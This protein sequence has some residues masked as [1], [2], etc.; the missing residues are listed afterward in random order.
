[1]KEWLFHEWMHIEFWR[2]LGAGAMILLLWPMNRFILFLFG[3]K[4]R[5]LAQ[6]TKSE[7]DDRLVEVLIP[8]LRNILYIL[9]YYIVFQII[10]LHGKAERYF[11]LVLHLLIG[12][13]IAFFVWRLIDIVTFYLLSL[14]NDPEIDFDEQFVYA[15]SKILRFLLVIISAVVI[16]GNMGYNVSGLIAGLGIGGLAVALAAQDTLANIFGSITLLADK[17]FKYKQFIRDG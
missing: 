10:P 13:N 17:P 14:A 3:K 8:V 4:A 1:M 16:A 15:V 12:L 11:T 5:Q 9:V 2:F 7:Y 6:Q